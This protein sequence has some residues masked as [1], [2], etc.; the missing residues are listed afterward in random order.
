MDTV[1]YIR[2]KQQQRNDEKQKLQQGQD[3]RNSRVMKNTGIGL[4]HGYPPDMKDV[5]RRVNEFDYQPTEDE[6]H[7]RRLTSGSWIDKPPPNQ[8]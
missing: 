3:N 6:I 1:Q 4:G 8:K 5:I 2:F 7:Y